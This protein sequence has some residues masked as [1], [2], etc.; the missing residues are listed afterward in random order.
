[1]QTPATLPLSFTTQGRALFSRGSSLLRQERKR[2]QR[3]KNFQARKINPGWL[4]GQ[5]AVPRL[6]TGAWKTKKLPFQLNS[7]ILCLDLNPGG[8]DD[9]ED[10]TDSLLALAKEAAPK[11]KVTK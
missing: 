4:A 1:M 6:E 3:K 11:E 9:E 8:A 2:N 7:G 5:P 10:A